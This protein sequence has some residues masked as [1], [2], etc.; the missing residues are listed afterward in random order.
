MLKG[1]LVSHINQLVKYDSIK[2]VGLFSASY[3][4][5]EHNR[6]TSI[7]INLKELKSLLGKHN[8]I[9]KES[10]AYFSEERTLLGN[11]RVY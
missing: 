1:Q 9:F 7:Q 11:E 4:R 5:I 10:K 3:E 8:T 6:T 2:D